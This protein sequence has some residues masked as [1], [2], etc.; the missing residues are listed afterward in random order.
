MTPDGSC[1]GDTGLQQVAF[2]G[3]TDT[4]SHLRIGGQVM[5]EM[6]AAR[7]VRF[8]LLTAIFHSPSYVITQADACNPNAD[9]SDDRRFGTCRSGII[10]PHHRP[11]IDLPGQR[12]R[13]ESL[14]QI[15]VAAYVT[16]Q[17]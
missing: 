4:Q 2:T 15:D 9:S 16:A 1:G 10:N 13:M 6:Q 11:A 5:L 7:Y 3:L 12:F 8:S 14:T 17:F